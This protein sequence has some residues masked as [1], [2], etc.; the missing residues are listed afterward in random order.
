[1][2]EYQNLLPTVFDQ[3]AEKIFSPHYCKPVLLRTFSKD[4]CLSDNHKTR[5]SLSFLHPVERETFNGYTLEKRRTEYLTGRVCAKLAVQNYHA[6]I[7]QI[8]T[9]FEPERIAVL[10]GVNGRPTISHK[11]NRLFPGLKVSI[12]HSQNYAVAAVS[13]QH[14]GIDIQYPS[15]TLLRVWEKYCTPEED[16]LLHLKL[17]DQKQLA[18]LA[19]IWAAKEAVQKN[20]IHNTMPGFLN[21]DLKAF[22]DTSTDNT[23]FYLVM[24]IRKGP[25]AHRLFHVAATLFNGYAIALSIKGNSQ[26]A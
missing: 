25:S 9:K 21:I 4:A 26:N 11:H 8:I 6:S 3:I 17:P 10:P 24:Q 20:T 12:S 18:R 15:D 14:C 22:N 19:I 7:R 1:M 13:R 23:R 16:R 2:H 5:E